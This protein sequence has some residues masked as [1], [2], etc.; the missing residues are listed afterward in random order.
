MARRVEVNC[1]EV[2]QLYEDQN[3]G[4]VPLA[5]RYGCS[6]TTIAKRLHKCGVKMRNSRFQLRPVSPDELRLFYEVERLPIK[7]IA[8]RLGVSVSTIGNRRR[9]LG[10][11]VR[12]RKL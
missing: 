5:Q 12:R 3:V 6:P 11:P 8:E 1:D 7:E 4:I 2:R 9:E 10:I